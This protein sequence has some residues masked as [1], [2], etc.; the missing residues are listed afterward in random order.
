MH[1]TWRTE[2]VYRHRARACASPRAT[3][4]RMR[5]AVRHAI[6]SIVSDGFTPPTVGNTEPSQTHRF[7]MSQLRQSLSTT[8]V[9]GPPKPISFHANGWL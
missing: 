4:A 5:S 1:A 2:T 8:L 9:A 6:A 7:G 3:I